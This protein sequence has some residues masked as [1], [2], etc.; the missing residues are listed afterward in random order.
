MK[1]I[2]L[3]LKQERYHLEH[4]IMRYAREQ[5]WTV[6]SVGG[7]IPQGWYGD[8]VI[9]DYFSMKE[10]RRLKKPDTVKIV[11]RILSPG[12]NIRCVMGNAFSIAQMAVEYFLNRGFHHFAAVSAW[13][14]NGETTHPNVTLKMALESRGY[15]LSDC[16]WNLSLPR[17]KR[18]DYDAVIQVLKKFLRELPKPCALFSPNVDYVHLINRA[19]DE[20][21][22]RIPHEIALLT[23]N[24][25]PRI[26][27]YSNPTTSAIFGEINDVGQKL[28]T[29][30]DRMMSGQEVPLQPEYM[31]PSGIITRQSTDILAVPDLAAAKAINFLLSNYMNP[32]SVEDAAIHAEIPLSTMNYL[33]RKY[34]DKSPGQLLLET[35]MNKIRQL[36]IHTGQTIAE[37]AVRTG[38]GS[39]MA[40][41]LAFKREHGGMTPGEYRKS[42]VRQ[43]DADI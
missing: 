23:N 25:E 11:S 7:V 19:C 1:R 13:P 37:I 28:A 8:G 33:L 27:E 5:G 32:I 34:I 18:D 38:Y 22:I 12:G 43:P 21:N 3:A 6:E 41:S 30:L 24:D 9:T 26:T 10:L 29:M 42:H 4:T 31:E 17:E 14:C 20:E 16:C 35:R 2:L 40:L 15:A 36:L 39:N